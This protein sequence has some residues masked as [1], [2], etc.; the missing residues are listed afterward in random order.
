MSTYRLNTIDH[1]IRN[2][3]SNLVVNQVD[4]NLIIGDVTGGG[5]WYSK[6]EFFRLRYEK[7]KQ[8]SNLSDGQN[9][10]EKELKS[11]AGKNLRVKTLFERATEKSK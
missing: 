1:F 8:T 11:G 2:E 7:C 5:K 10:I 6:D 4:G 3:H 9:T